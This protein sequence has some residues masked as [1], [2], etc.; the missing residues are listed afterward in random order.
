MKNGNEMRSY[1]RALCVVG[2]AC[3]MVVPV[4][5]SELSFTHKTMKAPLDVPTTIY[6]DGKNT[7]GPWDGTLEHPYQ[8]IQDGINNANAYDT[9]YVYNATYNER[10]AISLPLNLVGENM[11]TTIIDGN[12]SGSVVQIFADCVTLSGFTITNSGDNSDNAGVWIQASYCLITQNTIEKNDYYGVY[13][14]YCSN[15]LYH[16]NFIRNSYQAYDA[17]GENTWDNGYPCGGNYWSNY[18]GVDQM[19][20]PLQDQ[21]GFDGIGDTPY[22]INGD[23]VDHYPLIHPYGSIINENTSCIF[24]TIQDA[25]DAETTENGHHIFVKNGQ[26]DERDCIDKSLL[27]K[28]EDTEGTSIDGSG[29]GTVVRIVEDHVTLTGFTVR[30]SGND[31]HDAGVKVEAAFDTITGNVIKDN[32]QGV[33]L[34]SC[35]YNAVI[36]RN[37]ITVNNWNGVMINHG[38]TSSFVSENDITDNFF[39]GVGISQATGNFLFHNNFMRNRH[40]AYDDGTNIWDDGYPSGGNYWDDY[41]GVDRMHGTL[42]NQLGSDGIG[43]I[44]YLILSGINKDRYPFM[45]P[46]TGSDTTPPWL[47]LDSP[48]NGLYIRGHQHLAKILKHKTIIFGRITIAVEA[49]DIQGIKKVQFYVD[50]MMTPVAELTQ[51]PYR[52]T[53]KQHSMIRFKHTIDVSATDNEGNVNDIVFQVYKF[54]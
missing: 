32:Y 45:E 4:S 5:A 43:D 22:S 12:S 23:S 31:T 38:C 27:I 8:F 29:I 44:P 52:W 28:G 9:V 26:Y 15:T 13:V 30:D 34:T 6:V 20:G 3:L 33:I 24:L 19:K 41:A 14:A 48:T 36:Y 16:N 54:F 35:A 37:S 10:P 11:D 49:F 17:T 47:K 2:I 51:P 42:Q 50:D 40:N 25:I 46:Y 53:W 39:A 18:T 7:A 21:P 1:L